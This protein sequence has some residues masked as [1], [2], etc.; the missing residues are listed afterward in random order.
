MAARRTHARRDINLG[1]TLKLGQAGVAALGLA[2]GV[3]LVLQLHALFAELPALLEP[4][5]SVPH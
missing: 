5:I 3:A 2:T 4:L 1:T